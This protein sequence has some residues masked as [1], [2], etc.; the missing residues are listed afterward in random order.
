MPRV[1][2]IPLIGQIE[3]SRLGS[4]QGTHAIH[5]RAVSKPCTS[6]DVGEVITECIQEIILMDAKDRRYFK[7]DSVKVVVEFVL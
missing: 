2:V 5:E 6:E 1:R 3:K 4:M 7:A